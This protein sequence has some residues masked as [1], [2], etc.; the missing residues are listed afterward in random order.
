MYRS[1]AAR[2]TWSN[3]QMLFIKALHTFATSYFAGNAKITTEPGDDKDPKTAEGAPTT[4]EPAKLQC[5]PGQKER[6]TK[7]IANYVQSTG[8]DVGKRTKPAP[9]TEA[10]QMAAPP[11]DSGAGALPQLM[12]PAPVASPN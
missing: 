11:Q 10:P 9:S 1:E 8:V 4:V 12:T 6:V 5:P 3:E 7:S 2:K